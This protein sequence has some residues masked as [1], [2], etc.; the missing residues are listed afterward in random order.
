MQ[1]RH[2]LVQV[3]DGTYQLREI[4]SGIAKGITSFG[5][6]IGQHQTIESEQCTFYFVNSHISEECAY[7]IAQEL[8]Q[9]ILSS[10]R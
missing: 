7:N 1:D 4:D 5:C 10:N 3:A 6:V 9:D 2:F 8:T